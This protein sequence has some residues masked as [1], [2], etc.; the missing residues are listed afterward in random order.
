M[1]CV[2]RRACRWVPELK[3]LP[4]KYIHAPWSAPAATL[5]AAGVRLGETYPERITT[6]D[7]G[8]LRQRNVA[9][10]RAARAKHPDL[11][12]AGSYDV[13]PVPPGS[14]KGV[15]GD[16]VRVHTVPG[17]RGN[18][19]AGAAASGGRSKAKAK[20]GAHRRPAAQ[21]RKQ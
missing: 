9:A 3:K 1:G 10:L 6:E 11:I 8:V 17:L 13:V 4:S 12:D 7:L 20:A 21:R 16:V 15:R 2:G 19:K 18:G 5:A 14:A